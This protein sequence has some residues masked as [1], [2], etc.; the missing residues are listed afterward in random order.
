MALALTTT[1]DA[2]NTCLAVIGETPVNSLSTGLVDAVL[3][4]QTLDETMREVQMIGWHWNTDPNVTLSPTFPLPG[5]IYVPANTLSL[6]AV[7]PSV[8]VVVRGVKLW[9]RANQT[10]KFTQGVKVTIKRLLE[11]EEIPQ[12]ARHYI[13]IRTAR[14]FQDRVV[15]SQTL[16]GF[17]GTDEVR[18][19][20]TLRNDEAENADYTI[21]NNV[22]TLRILGGYPAKPWGGRY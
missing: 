13:M 6:D 2:V 19:L 9:D 17:S 8:D 14:K 18:A 5:D 1:L 4:K 22:D 10:F 21:F 7:D 11:F 3:A 12:V 16:S 15:G 20:V